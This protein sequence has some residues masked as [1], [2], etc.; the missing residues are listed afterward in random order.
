MV[1]KLAIPD[2]LRRQVRERAQRRC[3][4]CLVHEEDTYYPHDPDH[5][6]AE[7]HG[8]VTTF[9]NL[10]LACFPCNRF[11]GSDLAS[12]DPASQKIVILFHPREQKWQRHFCSDQ[13]KK[14]MKQLARL[15]HAHI[16]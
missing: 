10:A 6:I 12:I 9:E 1:K 15:F 5:I 2:R 3:E 7:K 14:R 4:Y 11:K 13:L 16:K 8:G